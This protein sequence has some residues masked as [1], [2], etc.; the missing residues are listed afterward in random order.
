MANL[1]VIVIGAG[2]AGVRAAERLVRAGLRPVV[3]DEARASGGQIYRRQP[4][5]F[6]RRASE[7]YGFETNRAQALHLAF[8]A[9]K[10]ALDYRPETLAWSLFGGRVNLCSSSGNESV[11]YD[12]LVL[13]T[14]AADRVFPVPGWTLP[15]VFSLGGAQIALKAQACVVGRRPVFLGTGPLLYLVAYQYAKVGVKPAMVLDTS[16]L[17]ARLTALPKLASRPLTLAKGLYYSLRLAAWRIPILTGITP[18]AIE[19]KESAACLR[20]RDRRSIEREVTCDAVGLGFGLR[21]ETQLAD[22]AG[23]RFAFDQV[24]RQWLPET[25]QDGRTSVPNVY[26]AGD[27]ARIAGADAAEIAGKLAACALLADFGH[28]V[29]QD[30]VDGHR[31]ELAPMTR[32]RDGLEQ[33]FPWPQRLAATLPDDAIVCRCEAIRASELRRSAKELGAPEVN[34]AKAFSRVGMGRCQGRYCGLAGA[35]ILAD[36]LRVPIEAVGRLRG[37]APVKPLPL[38]AEQIS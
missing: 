2:P 22:L 28:H 7:L 21:S 26:L 24:S 10:L 12:A 31:A 37:Q 30:E 38:A 6:E 35:E 11:P 18:I 25:D 16:P 36:A 27:G 34:R 17:S 23:C 32:F 3:V 8:D 20:F 14:G 1:R 33:A 4:V 15:G 13:A 29:P 5:N 9:A 19:G